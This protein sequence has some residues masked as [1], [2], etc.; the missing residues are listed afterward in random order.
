MIDAQRMLFLGSKSWI[1]DLSATKY[2]LYMS[3]PHMTIKGVN[4]LNRCIEETSK[5]LGI[6][7]LSTTV[8]E[9]INSLILNLTHD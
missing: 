3:I 6:D 7:L 4:I 5:L 8:Y 1:M 2:P 9:N